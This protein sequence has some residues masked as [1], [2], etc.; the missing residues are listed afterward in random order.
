MNSFLVPP[1][2]R[3]VGRERERALLQSLS[4]R[5][6]ATAVVVYGRPVSNM[7]RGWTFLLF[8]AIIHQLF[9]DKA[10]YNRA[11]F[12]IPLK[13]FNLLE[14]QEFLEKRIGFLSAV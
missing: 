10:F 12:E 6:E 5:G 11:G 9:S 14:T 2:V 13:P 4:A 8:S 3:F 7:P 1:N